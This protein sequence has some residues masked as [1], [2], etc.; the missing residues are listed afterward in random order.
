MFKKI[1]LLLLPAIL[2][3]GC[4]KEDTDDCAGGFRL[5]FRYTLNMRGQDLFSERVRDIRIYVFD[6]KT[7]VL[8]YIIYPTALDITRGYVDADIP[9]GN[10]TVA[11]WGGSGELDQNYSA[12]AVIGQTI[13]DDFRM[14]L[15]CDPFS[16]GSEGDVTP[17]T[18]DFSDLFF[19][20][21]QNIEVLTGARKTVDLDF[22]NNTCL[23]KI[24]VTG[25]EH[26]SSYT[27]ARRNASRAPGTNQPLAVFATARNG[28]YG[29]DNHTDAN[30]PLVRYEPPYRTLTATE[31]EVDVKVQRLEMEGGS[32]KPVLLYVRNMANSTDMILPLDV[33]DA[34]LKVTDPQ[35]NPLYQMQEDIDRQDEFP[36]VLSILHDLSVSVS[37]NGFEIVETK[38]GVNKP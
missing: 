35:G 31:M 33:M 25:L 13:L 11:A 37:V 28:V 21:A 34:I 20:A 10:Y 4:I 12:Q 30:A 9:D 32:V 24:K 17:S 1:V 6:R 7:G 22:I 29:H 8:A 3:A 14:A 15:A 23:L 36:I 5:E 27:P 2:L 18:I 19:A 26:L 16:G 38:P